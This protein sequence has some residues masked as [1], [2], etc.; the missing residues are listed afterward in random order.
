MKNIQVGTWIEFNDEVCEV[1]EVDETSGTLLVATDSTSYGTTNYE[2]LQDQVQQVYD[3]CPF[4]PAR[5][6]ILTSEESA[7]LEKN[8]QRWKD[9][10]KRKMAEHKKARKKWEEENDYDPTWIDNLYKKYK[11]SK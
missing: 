9:T 8:R 3:G 2:I 10:Y 11:E 4:T 7:E 6:Y 5:T 1:Y